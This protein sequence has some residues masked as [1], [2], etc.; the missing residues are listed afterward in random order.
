M[1]VPVEIMVGSTVVSS[2]LPISLVHTHLDEMD[3]NLRHWMS[4]YAECSNEL[5]G[6][7]EDGIPTH[8]EVYADLSGCVA[9]LYGDIKEFIAWREKGI[10]LIK[11]V[12]AYLSYLTKALSDD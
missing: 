8:F 4:D 3:T 1:T 10:P 9:T 6:F 2:T 11:G 7:N 12:E 5:S